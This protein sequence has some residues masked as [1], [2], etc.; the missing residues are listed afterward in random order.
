[1]VDAR[2]FSGTGNTLRAARW[3]GGED[4]DV[5][6]LDA[7]GATTLRDGALLLLASPTHGFTAPWGVVRFAWNLPWGAG[8]PAAVL[9]TRAGIP[10][11]R[12]HPPGLAGTAPFLLALALLLRG[13]RVRGALSVNMPSNW[14]SLHSG[15]TEA[16]ASRVLAHAEPL[17]RRFSQRVRGGGWCWLTGNLLYELIGGLALA[18]VSV[19]YLLVA[20][21][22]LGQY[23]FATRACTGC[24]HCALACPV[25]AIR[26]HGQPARPDWSSRCTSCMRCM[27]YC[28]RKAI[29]SSWSW[30]LLTTLLS[31]AP[32]GAWVAAFGVPQLGLL[33][34]CGATLAYLVFS[35]VVMPPLTRAWW[36]V[37]RRPRV[38]RL[39]MLT[40]PTH[41]Y[42]RYR[43]PKTRLL[44]LAPRLRKGR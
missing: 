3:F 44:E 39:F 33:G 24:G 15:L 4:A 14:V 5:R 20:T 38:N 30:A 32:G 9:C 25:G 40:T 43:E 2:V 41:W 36:R 19:V 31:L 37:L 13:Y 11:G 42:R 22:L 28:P 16:A 29:D 12:W 1:M 35:V 18:P 7:P 8:R 23:F 21:R 27:A 34:W 26:M 17:V 6:V 10:L